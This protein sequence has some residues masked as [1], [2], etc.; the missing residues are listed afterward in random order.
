MRASRTILLIACTLCLLYVHDVTAAFFNNEEKQW[1]KES[2]TKALFKF[3]YDF[4][5]GKFNGKASNG[6]SYLQVQSKHSPLYAN[7]KLLIKALE[8]TKH[9]NWKVRCYV[10]E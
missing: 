5:I 9:L 7:R 10:G 2:E 6:I 3:I 1:K 8:L 4:R